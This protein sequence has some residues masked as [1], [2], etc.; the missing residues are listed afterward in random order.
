MD[1]KA[2][3]AD[4]TGTNGSGIATRLDALC[5]AIPHIEI[6]EL[7][8][9]PPL[10]D[11]ESSAE[12][13]LFTRFLDGGSRGLYSA[14][15]VPANGAPSH[16]VIVEHGRVPAER[17]P[18]LIGQLQRRLGQGAPPRHVVIDGEQQRW[19]DLLNDARAAIRENGATGEN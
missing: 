18:R 2:V 17:V 7:W 14:R 12:F 5:K 16:Q 4:G 8:L 3:V 1:G 13:F 9:F 11:V 6:S 10:S 15:M 19:E